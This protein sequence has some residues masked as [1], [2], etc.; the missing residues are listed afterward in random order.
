M[1]WF[2][3]PPV[4]TGLAVMASSSLMAFVV[5]ACGASGGS[6]FGEDTDGGGKIDGGT[7]GTFDPGDG[8]PDPDAFFVKDPPQQ[9]CGPATKPPP[10][11][12]GGSLDCPSDKNIQGCPCLT[13]GERVKCYPGARATRGVGICQ[14]G[15][16]ECV[17]TG[18]VSKSW[19]PC[20][21]AVLPKPGAKT[22]KDACKCFSEGEWKIKNIARCTFFASATHDEAN[23]TK[24]TS[25]L[26]DGVT[27]ADPPTGV[28]SQD[29]L[30]VDCEGTF[31]LCYTIK[32][33][34]GAAK[35]PT[36]PVVG[37][38][39]TPAIDYPKANELV[40]LP[41]LGHWASDAA[42]GKAFFS[43]G[44]YGELTVKGKSYACDE[45]D[46][47]NG[48]ELV[49]QTIKYCPAKCDDASHKTDAECVNCTNGATGTFP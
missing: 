38:V 2:I 37:R 4:R 6:E 13:L 18:E 36:D 46:D 3:S 42:A 43:R 30:K 27:C 1:R 23:V 32:A 5:V 25:T 26:E 34:D 10:P 33:G 17:K 47:G 19:G 40:T 29:S 39:C 41:P 20:T 16:T 21:G 48:N 12:P 22:G 24:V 7:T 9:Y 44:G 14:E 31:T 28:W 8:A 11:T 15:E 49:F 45:V 35:L